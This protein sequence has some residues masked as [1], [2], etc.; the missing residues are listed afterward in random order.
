MKSR[1]PDELDGINLIIFLA[2][3]IT[4]ILLYYTTK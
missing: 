3:I 1:E 4:A 2:I